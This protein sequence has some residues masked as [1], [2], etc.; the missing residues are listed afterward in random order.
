MIGGE[1][2]GGASLG[3]GRDAFAR[4]KGLPQTAC[5]HPELLSP[6][7]SAPAP[8][9]P[10]NE[11]R[12]EVWRLPPQRARRQTEGEGGERQTAR[13][14][15]AK[16]SRGEAGNRRRAPGVRARALEGRE[17]RRGSGWGCYLTPDWESRSRRS[18]KKARRWLAP[19]GARAPRSAPLAEPCSRRRAN[20][21]PQRPNSRG[22]KA[23]A[24]APRP[25]SATPGRALSVSKVKGKKKEN[26]GISFSRMLIQGGSHERCPG[27]SVNTAKCIKLPFVI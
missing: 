15:K 21:I 11:E 25:P 1:G 12:V 6:K 7:L 23:A 9:R 17:S 8:A 14:A 5:S 10:G 2:A 27:G 4:H 16:G 3:G 22:A 24:Q 20:F 19:A 26:R 13:P 18:T